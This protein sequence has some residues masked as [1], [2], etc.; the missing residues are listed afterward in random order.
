MKNVEDEIRRPPQQNL[1]QLAV[2]ATL[3]S[4]LTALA[5]ASPSAAAL[6]SALGATAALAAFA[7][8]IGAGLAAFTA[9]FGSALGIVL[10]V[11]GAGRS[12]FACD[13][14]NFV[15]VPRCEA[16]VRRTA[17]LS[18]TIVFSHFISPC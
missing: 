7:T 10:E 18:A 3:V 2:A 11:A 13:V 1:S 4:S 12:A 17:A 9:C 16:A 5:A 15:F 8:A 14:S 6:A